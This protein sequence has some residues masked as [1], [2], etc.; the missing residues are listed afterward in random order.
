MSPGFVPGGL[1]GETQ[2]QTLKL[3]LGILAA[4]IVL[5]FVRDEEEE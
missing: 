2:M 5:A 4:L 3:I 1:F